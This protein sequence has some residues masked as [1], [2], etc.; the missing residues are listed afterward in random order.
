MMFSKK[1]FSAWRN[2]TVTGT[3]GRNK[4]V[5]MANDS[6]TRCCWNGKE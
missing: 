2:A 3:A 6:F 4:G 1:L 5:M